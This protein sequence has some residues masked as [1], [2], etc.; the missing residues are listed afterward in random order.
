MA[1]KLFTLNVFQYINAFLELGSTELVTVLIC[2]LR[3]S[4][5]GKISFN[6][7]AVF[8]LLQPNM[9][10]AF[11]NVRPCCRLMWSLMVTPGHWSPFLKSSYLAMWLIRSYEEPGLFAHKPKECFNSD[12]ISIVRKL[13]VLNLNWTSAVILPPQHFYNFYIPFSWPF[14][15]HFLCNSVH[16]LQIAENLWLGT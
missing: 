15:F 10:L 14:C 12:K 5:K 11:N 7:P 3:S 4:K 16:W 1:P 9:L 6:M 13:L 8:L 2:S